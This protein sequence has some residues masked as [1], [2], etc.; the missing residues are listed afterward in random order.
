MG[1][2]VGQVGGDRGAEV[3][4]VDLEA[5]AAG[6]HDRERLLVVRIAAGV[7]VCL[8]PDLALV[9]VFC[10]IVAALGVVPALYPFGQ[11]VPITAQSMGVMLAGALLGGP[12]AGRAPRG[13]CGR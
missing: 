1:R 5:R 13:R 8:I 4:I 9:A 6:A 7:G 12:R 3:G 11:A 2:D 10:G